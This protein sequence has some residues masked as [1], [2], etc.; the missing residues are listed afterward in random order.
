MPVLVTM[1]R[2]YV[3]VAVALPLA[4]K[5]LA[6][7]GRRVEASRGEGKLSSALQGGSRLISRRKDDEK[8][9]K[10]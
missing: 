9:G 5:G 10:H 2:R 7:L 6:A 4:A 8:R 1:V 3:L